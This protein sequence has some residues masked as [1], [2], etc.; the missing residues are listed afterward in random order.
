MKVMN[1]FHKTGPK[2]GFI[3]FVLYLYTCMLLLVKWIHMIITADYEQSD[4]IKICIFPSN[5]R[6]HG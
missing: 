3:I 5:N 1:P 2:P 6:L 4:H